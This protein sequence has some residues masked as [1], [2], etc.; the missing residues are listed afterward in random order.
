MFFL[1][2]RYLKHGRQFAKDARKV[3]AYKRDIWT[4]EQVTGF[5][6]AI[7]Q[8][9]AATKARSREQ[10]EVAARDLDA[11]CHANL[12]PQANAGWRENVE[13]FLVAIVVALGVRTYFL[14]PFTIP[15][16]SMYPTLNGIIGNKTETPEP[17][18]VVQVWDKIWHGR[19]WVDVAAKSDERIVDLKE[20][21]RYLFF[22]YT[23]VDTDRNVYYLHVP[24][25]TATARPSNQNPDAFGLM[26]GQSFRAGEPIM[27][28]YHDTGDHVFV[29]KMTYHFR[30]PRREEVFVFN[31]AGIQT[32]ENRGNPNAPSQFYIKRLCG[33]PLDELRIDA[34]NLYVNGEQARGES[35]ARV[36]SMAHG[37]GGY[38]NG[39][40][41]FLMPIL[42]SA[43]QVFKVPP[44]HYFAL[45]DNSYHSSDSRDWGP[46]PQRNIVGRG[47]FVYWPF[48]PHFGGIR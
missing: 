37:Y 11:L 1:T 17:N 33:E 15:T 22:T 20:A 27:R 3:L 42:Q 34:P 29:D 14:Q 36:M 6:Q 4:P 39:F 46:V 47:L 24:L 13:V 32:L 28:G 35:F 38:A 30:K 9:E 26:V 40:R 12:P 7:E 31:T 44:E 41:S 18:P 48:A 43:E 8:L 10:V 16:G 2:P 23:R 19:T 21:K 45:G 5:T 25:N